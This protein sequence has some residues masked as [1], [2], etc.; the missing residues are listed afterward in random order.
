[1]KTKPDSASEYWERREARAFNRWRAA[2][3]RE[4]KANGWYHAIWNPKGKL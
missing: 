1:M 2:K 4:Y 3:R